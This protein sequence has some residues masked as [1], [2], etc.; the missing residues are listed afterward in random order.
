MWA[1]QA[2]VRAQLLKAK[3]VGR[4]NELHAMQSSICPY[5]NLSPGTVSRDDVVAIREPL[6][7][8]RVCCT[9][10]KAVDVLLIGE[11]HKHRVLC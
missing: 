9:L 10:N 6:S 8:G 2:A 4:T 11:P 7:A 3:G 1:D 5:K